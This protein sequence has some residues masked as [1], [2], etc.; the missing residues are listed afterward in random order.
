MFDPCILYCTQLS[1]S[2]ADLFGLE[3]CPPPTC[4][5]T[6]LASKTDESLRYAVPLIGIKS[7]VKKIFIIR[8][9]ELGQSSVAGIGNCI[10]LL[11]Q[12]I[13]FSIMT[14][15]ESSPPA[16]TIDHDNTQKDPG[17]LIILHY[18]D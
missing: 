6:V 3:K 18:C 11:Y 14:E 13:Y 10:Q 9:P 17:L 2:D 8:T 12:I 7:P 16:G 15:I 5:V 1:K 4:L